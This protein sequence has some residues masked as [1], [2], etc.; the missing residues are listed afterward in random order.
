M[1][2]PRSRSPSLGR[3]LAVSGALHGAALVALLVLGAGGA[4]VQAPVYRVEL[5]AAPRGERAIG[6]VGATATSQQAT[7][8]VTPPPPEERPVLTERSP[9]RTPTRAT[10]SPAAQSTRAPQQATRAG[11]GPEG[12]TGTDVA[13]VSTGGIAF[14]YPEY[15][16]NIVRQVQLRFKPRAAGN[17][18]AEV[19]FLIRRDGS[20]HEMQVQRRSGS[21]PFDL[22]AQGAVESAAAARAFGPLPRGWG[23]DVLRVIFTFEPGL[24]Q[25]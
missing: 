18:V 10:P 3:S 5:I 24:I 20:V 6:V 17:L 16:N 9:R 15:L 22:E 2:A 21:L 1:A 14:P 12:G 19:V 4:A 11:G 8:K 23:D 13:N 25:R 7:P